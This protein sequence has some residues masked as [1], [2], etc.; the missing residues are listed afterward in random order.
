MSIAQTGYTYFSCA[1]KF[2]FPENSTEWCGNA[3]WFPGFPI[4]IRITGFFSEDLVLVGSLLT[5]TF[6][7]L[8]L[9][10]VAR[11][12]NLRGIAWANFIYLSIAAFFFGSIYYSAVFPISSVI[13]FA[14]VG[15]YFYQ[16]GNMWITGFCC[17]LAAL[18]YPTGFLLA[19]VFTL[20][21]LIADPRAFIQKIP[22]AS[23]P[24]VCGGLGSVLVFI[25]F[26]IAVGDPLAFI[27]V[28]AKYGHTFENPFKMIAGA[29]SFANFSAEEPIKNATHFQSFF[30]LIGYALAT[31]LFFKKKMYRNTLNLWSYIYFS[32]YLIFPWCLG[33][34]LSRYRAEALLMPCV[35][36]L[37]DLN[38]D[39]NALILGYMLMIAIPMSYLFF[40][41]GLV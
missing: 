37:K 13:F 19:F 24:L 21:Y 40:T 6:Y 38:S 14:L 10:L 27:H 36:L 31:I 23:I 8:S 18:F 39:W 4:L 16:R 35:F 34:D 1:G 20:T 5:K 32:M 15:F 2:W 22:R 33:G 41:Y 12:A 26:Q 25:I 29:F 28:Q 9:V 7:F 17:F 30:V 3:G 11:I